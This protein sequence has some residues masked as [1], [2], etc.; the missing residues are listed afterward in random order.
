MGDNY[1]IILLDSSA[2]SFCYYDKDN[3][4]EAISLGNLEKAI[5]YCRKY[6]LFATIIYP[7]YELNG[8][9]Q[10]LLNNFEHV[11]IIPSLKAKESTD[12]DMLVIDYDAGDEQFEKIPTNSHLN[13]ILRLEMSRMRD[14]ESIYHN[15][16]DRFRRLTIILTDIVNADEEALNRYRLDLAKVKDYIYRGWNFDHEFQMSVITDRI[17]LRRMNNCNAGITHF[18]I[19]PNGNFY[20][21][22]G[23]YIENPSQSIGSLSQGMNAI[24]NSHLLNIDNSTVC[25][26]CDCY[27]CKRCVYL[28]KKTTLEVNIPS[29]QQCVVSHHERNVS[30]VLLEN[31]QRLEMFAEIPRIEPLFY[32]DPFEIV[33]SK[34]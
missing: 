34:L 24:P 11:R 4:S 32:L 5:G 15:Y 20:I 16:R 13:I 1:V 29:H 26:A 30:G 31:F 9:K 7:D 23:F 18:T 25:S 10:K 28:N 21:C 14:L 6:N 17:M 33:K 27:H 22:P 3:K 8:A 19:A 12:D 2:P